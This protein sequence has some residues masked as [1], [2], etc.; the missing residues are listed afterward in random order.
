VAGV[1]GRIHRDDEVEDRRPGRV[2]VP[3]D[4]DLVPRGQPLDVRGE[5]VLSG[6]G[7]PHPEDRVH[8]QAVRARR[9][10]AVDGAD[11][12][13]EVVHAWRAVEA[14]RCGSPSGCGTHT[15]SFRADGS[16]AETRGARWRQGTRAG[17]TPAADRGGSAAMLYVD[18]ATAVGPRVRRRAGRPPRLPRPPPTR[19]EASAPM[20]FRFH[21]GRA[22]PA[23]PPTLAAPP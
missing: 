21:R 8:D 17:G 16:A 4:P 3:A 1:R 10:R 22:A 2:A 19:R 9:A 11:L 12:E 5:D 15:F 13:R 7:D 6:D 18:P 23:T 14:R 20:H